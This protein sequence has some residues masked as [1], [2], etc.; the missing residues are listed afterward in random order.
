MDEVFELNLA[1]NPLRYAFRYPKTRLYFRSW[2]RPCGGAPDI[3][4]SSEEISRAHAVMPEKNAEDYAEFKALC[5]LTGQYLLRR[6][7]CVFHAVAFLFRGQAWL[8]TAPSGT[9]K[10]TQFMNWRRLLPAEITM[11][12]G[13]M[14]V[15]ERKDDVITVH[16]SP[17][18]GKEDIGSFLSAPLGGVVLLEQGRENRVDPIP[19]R[20]A[21]VALM[22]QFVADPSTEEEILTLCRILDSILHRPVWKLVNTGDLASTE[23]L[24]ET[25]KG[26]CNET[27]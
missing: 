18:N 9:G 8:L 22:R 4:A 13:D 5:G 10:T 24:R 23:L 14:P 19:A 2:L 16:P 1:G 3:M 25:M 21:I 11:I 27:V 12:C 6:D 20:E 17:W 7:C 15:L 26:G